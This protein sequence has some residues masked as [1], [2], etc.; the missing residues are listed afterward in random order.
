MSDEKLDILLNE[1]QGIKKA[2][3]S[4]KSEIKSMQGDIGSIKTEVGTIKT[5]ARTIKTQLHENTQFIKAIHHRQ[6]ETDAK[7]EA[8]SLDVAK[9]HGEILSVKTSVAQIIEDQKSIHEL[10]GEHEVSIRSLRRKPV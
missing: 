5:D 2:M 4:M 6:E 3:G 10:L 1:M 9:S 8:M 7:L